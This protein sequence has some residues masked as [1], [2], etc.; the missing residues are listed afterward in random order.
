MSNCGI[1]LFFIKNKIALLQFSEFLYEEI[2]TS[3]L[4]PKPLSLSKKGFIEAPI[5]CYFLDCIRSM[6]QH[7]RQTWIQTSELFS[8]KMH[9]MFGLQERGSSSLTTSPMLPTC[10]AGWICWEK[11]GLGGQGESLDRVSLLRALGSPTEISWFLHAGVE[12]GNER[13]KDI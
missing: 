5:S 9:E 7:V 12:V 6:S 8:N 3:Y 4:E 2:T 13:Q 10:S 11:H 1:K